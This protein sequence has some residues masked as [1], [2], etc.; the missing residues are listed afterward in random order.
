MINPLP[1]LAEESKNLDKI[2]LDFVK[3]Y[4]NEVEQAESELLDL[5]ENFDVTANS[6]IHL[7]SSSDS[8]GNITE[9][10]FY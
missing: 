7:V 1:P 10:S 2:I 4:A 3:E 5:E 9:V 6:L 8:D